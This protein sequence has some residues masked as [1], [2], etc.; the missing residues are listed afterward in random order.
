[1]FKQIKQA[2]NRAVTSLD[3]HSEIVRAQTEA[4]KLQTEVVRALI[5]ELKASIAAVEK[6]VKYLADSQR[7]ELQRSGHAHDF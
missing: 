5:P 1:M 4:L 6:H 2:F 3:A 7:R